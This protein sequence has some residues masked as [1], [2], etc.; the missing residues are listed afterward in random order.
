MRVAG[1][2][3]DI[4]WE[5]PVETFRRA[6]VL[7][8]EAAAHGGRVLALPETFATGFSMRAEEMAR[9]AGAVRDFLAK[10]ARRLEVWLLAGLAEPGRELAGVDS[11]IARL[12]GR[13]LAAPLLLGPAG[14]S[15]VGS[16]A[17]QHRRWQQ[18]GEERE[19]P[20]RAEHAASIASRRGAPCPR[21]LRAEPGRSILGFDAR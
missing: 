10:L 16:R 1:L 21:N 7:A 13:G 18:T 4:A 6:E 2:Q 20:D 11:P 8:E 17:A 9:H 5:N 15:L 14:R 12:A 3:L 19:E